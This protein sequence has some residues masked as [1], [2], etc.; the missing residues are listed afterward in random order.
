MDENNGR[1]SVS[2]IWIVSRNGIVAELTSA[3][4]VSAAEDLAILSTISGCLT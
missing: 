4:E 1:S 2:K 3:A